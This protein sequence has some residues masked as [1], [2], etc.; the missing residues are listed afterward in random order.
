V[1]RF[2]PEQIF[3]TL[4]DHD[5][6]YVVVGMLAA[7]LHGSPLR[8]GD[9]DI[10]PSTNAANLERLASAL[11][12]MDPR[13]R[14]LVDP[15]DPA[16]EA[17]FPCDAARLAKE[18]GSLLLSTRYGDLDIV[19][20]PDGTAGYEDLVLNVVRYDLGNGLLVPVASLEDVIR[21]KTAAGRPKDL[22]ALPTLRALLRNR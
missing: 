3:L 18:R 12:E 14:G 1:P 22:Y 10:C 7:T 15:L 16:G 4:A 5:V 2:Q 21:S 8:T 13:V 11:T 6:E 20:R 9:A 17:P 19:F